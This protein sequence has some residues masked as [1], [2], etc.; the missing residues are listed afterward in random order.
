MTTSAVSIFAGLGFH[1]VFY[2]SSI[3]LVPD[4][5]KKEEAVFMRSKFG[6]AV[7][8]DKSG[9]AYRSNLKKETKIYWRCRDSERYKCCARAVTDGFYVINWTGSHNHSLSN[10][11]KE[12]TNKSEF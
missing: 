9:Y 2:H 7:L 4:P 8:M 6:N 12:K 1:I 10:G 3:S 11:T 5:E